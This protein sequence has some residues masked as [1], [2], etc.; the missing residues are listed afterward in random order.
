M[1]KEIIDILSG[2]HR[3]FDSL[4]DRLRQ[5]KNKTNTCFCIEK[6][7]NSKYTPNNIVE[8]VLLNI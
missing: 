7:Q 8:S 6:V 4:H 2:R 5:A 3:N 1:R